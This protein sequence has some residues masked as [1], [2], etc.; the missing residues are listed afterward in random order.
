MLSNFL[1]DF[2]TEKN[3]TLNKDQFLLKLHG[4]TNMYQMT[5]ATRYNTDRSN[6][7]L[8][9]WFAYFTKKEYVKCL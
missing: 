2:E 7:F 5:R 3:I 9:A 1:Y 6:I 4:F 8:N